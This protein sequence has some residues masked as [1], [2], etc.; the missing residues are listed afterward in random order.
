MLS[1]MRSWTRIHRMTMVGNICAG[2][3]SLVFLLILAT[4]ALGSKKSAEVTG[5]FIVFG[6][7]SLLLFLLLCGAF[8]VLIARRELDWLGWGREMQYLGVIVSC[9]TLSIVIG[10]SATLRSAPVSDVPWAI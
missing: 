5:D 9:L 4:V 1:R 7:A 8:C 2:L 6:I 10:F 3:A